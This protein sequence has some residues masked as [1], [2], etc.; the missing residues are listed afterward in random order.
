MSPTTRILRTTV[1]AVALVAIPD[2]GF[3]GIGVRHHNQLL[4]DVGI[5]RQVRRIDG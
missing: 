2:D 4:H 5:A 3:G 1:L